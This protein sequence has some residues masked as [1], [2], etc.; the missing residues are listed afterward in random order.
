ML[1]LKNLVKDHFGSSL[2]SSASIETTAAEAA[3]SDATSNT[4][5]G[6]VST[7]VNN[8]YASGEAYTDAVTSPVNSTAVE[9]GAVTSSLNS[10]SVAT[11]AISTAK[12]TITA[13]KIAMIAA[14]A[15]ACI[16]LGF[17]SAFL[18][19][20]IITNND[21]P[22]NDDPPYINDPAESPDTDESTSTPEP[23][24][25]AVDSSQILLAPTPVPDPVELLK[26]PWFYAYM[27]FVLNEEY[28]N[29]IND[30]PSGDDGMPVV[31]VHFMLHDLNADGIP[32]L[33]LKT[34]T[35][36][37]GDGAGASVMHTFTYDDGSV[38]RIGMDYQLTD[39]V[40]TAHE[41][42]L[43]GL[44]EVSHGWGEYWVN[45]IEMK[46]SEYSK[47][48]VFNSIV[49]YFDDGENSTF[50]YTEVSRTPNSA[51]Y[52]AFMAS[53]ADLYPDYSYKEDNLIESYTL[54]EIRELG[55][56]EFVRRVYRN[57]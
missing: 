40:F 30:R 25:D 2:P 57:P 3:N 9:G 41:F 31:R 43:S 50:S 24:P 23:T 51:L 55:W 21:N 4:T 44:F 11:A 32:E 26:G 54:E 10:T 45:Y 5:N 8:T 14:I 12:V 48:L 22:N 37:G 39:L 56:E 13:S 28:S 42:G 53:G 36:F 33:L 27:E 49:Q 38:V 15:V 6:D 34:D 16:G 47:S 1:A 7:T 29:I 35:G 17:F 20:S 19:N 18:V 46:N 52:D